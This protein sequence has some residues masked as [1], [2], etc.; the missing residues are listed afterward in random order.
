MNLK[1]QS[2][3]DGFV[4]N[5]AITNKEINK[6]IKLLQ[7][8]KPRIKPRSGKNKG[9]GFQQEVSLEE[10]LN[11]RMIAKPLRRLMCC[12]NGD[13]KCHYKGRSLR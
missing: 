11:S 10:V 7:K 8:I 13:D 2:T 5:R 3:K 1:L 4:F 6:A 12:A 9:A